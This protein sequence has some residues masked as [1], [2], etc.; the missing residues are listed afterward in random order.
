MPG[1]ISGYDGLHLSPGWLRGR[2]DHDFICC[3]SAPVLYRTFQRRD[4]PITCEG[5]HGLLYCSRSY[6]RQISSPCL[7]KQTPH[8]GQ[9]RPTQRAVS[10]C[11]Y[12][13]KGPRIRRSPHAKQTTIPNRGNPAF[14]KR[15]AA[16]PVIFDK[17]T[18]R[19]TNSNPLD[20]DRRTTPIIQNMVSRR[21]T[22]FSSGP[23]SGC[24]AVEC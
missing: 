20:I 17:I 4:H 22:T 18:N 23:I 16:V 13:V 8:Q 24:V 9:N 19:Q 12:T 5:I 11:Y 1:V 6:C 15:S 14:H 10:P 2:N 21:R 7:S 3:L